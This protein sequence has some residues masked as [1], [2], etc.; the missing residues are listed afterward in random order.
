MYINPTCQDAG[1]T[2]SWGKCHS[3]S[4]WMEQFREYW[5]LQ[6]VDIEWYWYW[7][8]IDIYILS[9]LR[10]D[11]CTSRIFYTLYVWNYLNMFYIFWCVDSGRYLQR[12]WKKWGGYLHQALHRSHICL[13]F[14]AIA[15]SI[16]ALNWDGIWTEDEWETMSL[17]IDLVW[18]Y[19]VG[20]AVWFF[21]VQDVRFAATICDNPVIHSCLQGKGWLDDDLILQRRSLNKATIE[22]KLHMYKVVALL[23]NLR[24]SDT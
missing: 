12:H 2:A 23:V 13:A 1:R 11:M 22:H 7:Y 16:E 18:S 20:D 3:G 5:R 24:N 8:P 17:I 14:E 19:G 21:V 15:A 9:V 4:S 10:L 6:Y